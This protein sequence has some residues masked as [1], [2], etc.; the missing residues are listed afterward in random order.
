VTGGG[1]NA[2]GQRLG[3]LEL[4][5]RRV[6]V[7]TVGAGPPL[8]CDLGQLG[9]LDV[10]W[11]YPPYRRLVEGLARSFTVIR[12]DRPGFG[13]SDRAGADLT[14]DA[15]IDLFDRLVHG[16][17]IQAPAVLA[18]GSAARAMI[19]VAAARPGHVR[20]LALFGARAGPIEG[21]TDYRDAVEGLLRAEVAVG[22]SLL[23]RM[24]GEGCGPAA[25]R[26]LAAAYRQAA[27]GDVLARWL[28]ASTELDVR[29]LVG[30]VGCPTLVLHRRDDRLTDLW[31]ARDVAARVVDGLLVPLDGGES[32]VWEGDVV[33]LA[34]QIVRFMG[35]GDGSGRRSDGAGLTGREREVA[36]LVSDGLTNAQI[37]GRLGIG[38]RTV[39]SHLERARSKLGLQSRADLAAWTARSR[40]R[41]AGGPAGCEER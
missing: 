35:T 34:A 7:A 15:E 25:V 3:F 13:L 19:A 28:R 20:R 32:L 31:E 29:H 18:S 21:G 23:A 38:R 33:P 5:G 30:R 17:D 39:E 26:W 41:H 24:M 12:F 16:L 1:G 6:A 14:L 8:L 27:S 2:T 22:A 37:G 4:R 10:F 36:V 9:H 40:I 11:R